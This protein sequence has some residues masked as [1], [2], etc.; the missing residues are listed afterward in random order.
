MYWKEKNSISFVTVKK[1]RPLPPDESLVKIKTLL[2]MNIRQI[3]KST[4]A[5]LALIF[6]FQSCSIEKRVHTSGYHIA[7]HKSSKSI[8]TAS[9]ENSENV[10]KDVIASENFQPQNQTNEAFIASN[11]D[12]YIELPEPKT[13]N[14]IKTIQTQKQLVNQE[15]DLI[16]LTNGDE[17]S[18]KVLEVGSYEVKYL[19]CDNLDGP[20]FTLRRHE[21]FMI[22]HPN[23]SK[24]VLNDPSAS[25]ESNDSYTDDD[26]IKTIDS[27]DKSFLVAVGLWFFLG[28]IGIHRFYLGHI[29]MGVLYLL[30]GG[31]C[32]I[33]WLVDGILFLTGSLKPK[34]GKYI[35][36]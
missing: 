6:L 21:I 22:K 26:Y 11:D 30:T 34:K 27:N 20:T 24:T 1:R 4:L 14:S 19:K 36:M 23:G 33:G 10:E 2:K 5:I 18:G 16:I 29:G 13:L 8:S 31:L 9:N 28:L 17:I 15:C 35:D 25:N 12:S 32:G 3:K 7:W